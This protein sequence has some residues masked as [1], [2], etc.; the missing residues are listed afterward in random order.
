MEAPADLGQESQRARIQALRASLRWLL[1]GADDPP[2]PSALSAAIHVLGALPVGPGG[3]GWLKPFAAASPASL[4][5][6]LAGPEEAHREAVAPATVL[7]QLWQVVECIKAGCAGARVAAG[8]QAPASPAAG[9]AGPAAASGA[10]AAAAAAAWADAFVASGVAAAA[11]LLAAALPDGPAAH[12][13]W[14]LRAALEQSGCAPLQVSPAA[15]IVHAWAQGAGA[16]NAAFGWAAAG[17]H[18]CGRD[19]G[20]G[21]PDQDSFM[22]VPSLHARGIRY[23]RVDAHPAQPGYMSSILCQRTDTCT[24]CTTA[25]ANGRGALPAPSCCHAKRPLMPTHG[26]RTHT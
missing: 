26:P 19:V 3:Q 17:S 16:L 22:W 10:D 11:A 24:A 4:Q 25:T 7:R 13:A 12:H 18:A 21:A 6:A 5:A 9:H 2:A 20:A 15:A 1:R 14:Q 8:A 23:A